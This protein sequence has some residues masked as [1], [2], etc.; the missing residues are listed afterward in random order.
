MTDNDNI[1]VPAPVLIRSWRRQIMPVAVLMLGVS[2]I[3]LLLWVNRISE[4][5]LVNSA[6][7]DALMDVETHTA[8]VHLWLEEAI[9]GDTDVDVKKQLSDLNKAINLVNVILEGGR[10]EHC[11]VVRPM[12]D[13]VARAEANALKSLLYRFKEIGLVRLKDPQ[14]A[15]IGSPLDQRFDRVFDE[16]IGKAA[17]LEDMFEAQR[18]RD[19]AEAQNLFLGGVIAWTFIVTFATAGI[20]NREWRRRRAEM[21]LLAANERLSA[22]TEELASHRERLGEMVE[23]R[24]A[25]LKSANEQLRV[26]VAERIEADKALRETEKQVGD[27]SARLLDAQEAERKRISMELHDE[28]GQALNIMKFRIRAIEKGL[29]ED[30]GR[31]RD[32]CDYL[33]EYINHVIEEV[34]RL[35]LHLSPTVLED[36]G[37]TS[38][39]QWLASN[40]SDSSGVKLTPDIEDIDH[41]FPKHNW[42]T[43]YRV[44][45]EALT[46]I[47][48]HAHAGNVTLAIRRDEDAVVFSV[49]DDGIGFDPEGARMNDITERG[50]GLATMDERVRMLGGTLDLWSQ[51]GVGTR[52]TFRI[53]VEKGGL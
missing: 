41:L 19:H 10:T 42:I 31:L 22:Q 37:V 5:Q 2:S 29:G 16:I 34:R 12:K 52:L 6:H 14:S 4:R 9:Y 21:A 20:W 35:S 27:L 43:I 8:T 25:R 47:S 36:L 33:L 32:D 26:E 50:L 49:V 3:F 44:I 53:P 18:A 17:G 39:I 45:Q 13:P 11:E 24:T 7:I 38:A 48:K 46:N 23:E 28:L 51:G 30:Q 1:K 15:Q 40:F